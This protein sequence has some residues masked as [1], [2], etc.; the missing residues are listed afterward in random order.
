MFPN[1]GHLRTLEN[2]KTASWGLK[3]G[4]SPQPFHDPVV[5]LSCLIW[6]S[7]SK[8][9]LIDHF[10]VVCLVPWPLNESEAGV[11]LV[12]IE[13]SLLFICKFPLI[14]MRTAS[15]TWES[16]EVS[17]KTRSPPASLSFKGQATKQETVKCSIRPTGP[18]I[19]RSPQ[20]LSLMLF[21][22]CGE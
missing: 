15:L 1:R 8:T 14:S 6:T 12:L 2:N 13:T 10:T 16:R 22:Y 21:E 19:L 18:W 20:K 5:S 11:D 7:T 9:L 3:A 17:I 4:L